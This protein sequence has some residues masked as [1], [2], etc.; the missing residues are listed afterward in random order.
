MDTWFFTHAGRGK[1]KSV[2]HEW[3][4]DNLAA[5]AANAYAEGEP[6]SASGTV[7]PSRLKNSTMITRRDF[8]V[9][10]TA[11]NNNRY[12]QWLCPELIALFNATPGANADK[13]AAVFARMYADLHQGRTPPAEVTTEVAAWNAWLLTQVTGS[14]DADVRRRTGWLVAMITCL[15]EYWR[16]R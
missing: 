14:A 1:A 3:L 8:A 10:G 7:N 16:I 15:P 2:T 6:F 12:G 13:N 9:T 4:V 5:P 11:Q